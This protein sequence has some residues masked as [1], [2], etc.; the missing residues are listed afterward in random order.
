MKLSSGFISSF[1]LQR[2]HSAVA[3]DRSLLSR[4]SEPMAYSLRQIRP[5]CDTDTNDCAYKQLLTGYRFNN[6]WVCY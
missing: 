3:L 2:G 1:C 6:L 4:R 5:N